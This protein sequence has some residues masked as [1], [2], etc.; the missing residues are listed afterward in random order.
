[1]KEYEAILRL[2]KGVMVREGDTLVSEP[3]KDALMQGVF[4]S[5]GFPDVIIK[6]AI[7]QYGRNGE[8]ANQT[9]HKSLWHKLL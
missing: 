9:F 1:M 5:N 7:K 3:N 6:E 4:I 8:E 2:F